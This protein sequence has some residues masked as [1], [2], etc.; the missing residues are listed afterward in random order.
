MIWGL[1]TAMA[2]AIALAFWGGGVWPAEIFLSLLPQLSLSAAGLS[3]L[4]LILR[5]YAAAGLALMLGLAALYGARAQFTPADPQLSA[6]DARIVWANVFKRESALIKTLD[7]AD[8]VKAD[9]VLIAEFPAALM[10]ASHQAFASAH[11]DGRLNKAKGADI[12]SAYPYI[13]RAGRVVGDRASPLDASA[14]AVLSRTPIKSVITPNSDGK[15]GIFFRA[16]LKGRALQIGGVHPI[17]PKSPSAVRRRD[18]QILDVFEQ[19]D[20]T[21][22]ALVTGDFNTVTWSP[23]LKGVERHFA[24]TRLSV[25]PAA[26]WFSPAPLIGLPIDHAFVRGLAGSARLGPAI[27]SDHRPLVIDIAFK[28]GDAK[29]EAKLAQQR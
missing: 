14:I 10:G 7:Y 27:G 13:Y 16:Q 4:A 5:R 28:E 22:P 24:M 19:L 26:T 17:I 23:S 15:D 8:E 21:A 9:I 6:P 12:L 25:G 29:P 3:A 18:Q 20:A 11:Q 2:G 1:V